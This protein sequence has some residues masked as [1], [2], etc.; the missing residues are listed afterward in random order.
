MLQPLN[1]RSSEG[2]NW[3]FHTFWS[4]TT[5][6]YCKTLLFSENR[7]ESEMHVDRLKLGC[8]S[9]FSACINKWNSTAKQSESRSQYFS[10]QYSDLRHRAMFEIIPWSNLKCLPHVLMINNC[11]SRSLH[12][13][14]QLA[15][16]NDMGKISVEDEANDG[17]ENDEWHQLR[18]TT[19]T[20]KGRRSDWETLRILND[21]SARQR[22]RRMVHRVH[23]NFPSTGL[24]YQTIF[25]A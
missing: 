7:E 25:H 2:M 24:Q 9:P 1:K 6:L 14:P 12:F 22:R 10:F 4:K 17:T 19:D 15:N 23:C 3:L 13:P 16:K 5:T 18:R 20:E 11:N 8:C 21:L